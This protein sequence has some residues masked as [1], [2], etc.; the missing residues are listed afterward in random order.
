M[1]IVVMSQNY[2]S[3][4]TF[5]NLRFKSKINTAEQGFT[6]IE[7]LVVII[8]GGIL[9][10]IAFPSFLNQANKARESEARTYVGT[11]NR[12]Q[13]A[14]FLQESEFAD[15]LIRLSLGLSDTE[16]YA[17]KTEAVIDTDGS[18]VAYTTA[19]QLNPALRSFSGQTWNGV[20]GN[21]L[22]TLS[23]F[24]ESEPGA[25]PPPI[26]NHQCQ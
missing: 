15:S 21:D 6:L 25:G 9:S 1:G 18:D 24:C 3:H 8:I 17:Y 2:A 16:N 4:I 20:F 22:L 12:A 23:V 11:V 5:L 7:L 26:T 19:D 10:A 13:Q 14:Y